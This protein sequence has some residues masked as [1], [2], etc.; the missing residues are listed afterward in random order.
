[1]GELERKLPAAIRGE[2][3]ENFPFSRRVL[4]QKPQDTDKIYS[5][6]EPHI[7]C[8]AKDKEAQEI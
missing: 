3:E 6:H 1:M 2:Q 7:Y 5:L 4:A 8:V